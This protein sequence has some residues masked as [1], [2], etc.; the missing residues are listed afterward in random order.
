[1]NGHSLSFRVPDYGSALQRRQAGGR[2]DPRASVHPFI[3]AGDGK[4]ESRGG[5]SAHPEAPQQQGDGADFF[6]LAALH[7]GAARRVQSP[8]SIGR[9]LG[10]YDLVGYDTV[11]GDSMTLVATLEG[12]NGLVMAAD[13]RG[14]I[15]DPRGLT[16]INDTQTKL[17][18]LASGVVSGCRDI[19]TG[20]DAD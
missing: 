3:A 10:S 19:G 2:A 18:R 14:T 4:S 17:F 20:Y 13:S 11:G 6:D 15:G 9:L 7:G 16:A 8:P 1:M 5:A 12:K